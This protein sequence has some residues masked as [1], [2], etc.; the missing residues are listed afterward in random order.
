MNNNSQGTPDTAVS[1]FGQANGTND[2]P[3]LKAFQEYIDAEQAKARKR[4]LGLS[5]FFIVLLTI[6]VVTFTLVVIGVINRNQSLS[7][8]LLEFA[9]RQSTQQAQP[10][11][12]PQQPALQ[13][14][15]A[16]QQPAAAVQH[17]STPPPDLKPVLEKLEM[18]A[19]AI[20]NQ[21]PQPV[22]QPVQPVVQ[23]QPM[24]VTAP[25]PAPQAQAVPAQAPKPVS[26]PALAD[27]EAERIR[28]QLKQERE[29]LA[30]ERKQLEEQRHKE[31]VEKHRRRLYPEYYAKKDAAAKKDVATKDV[32]TKPKESQKPP[33]P[34]ELD[35]IKPKGYFDRNGDAEDEEL[36]EMAR[37]AARRKA[38]ADAAR[39]KAEADAAEAASR[40]AASEAARQ[41]AE[42]AAADA[43]RRK[44][45]ADAARQK[46]EADAAEAKK[47]KAE[48]DADEAKKREAAAEEAPR[49]KESQPPS[50]A[51][52]TSQSKTETIEVGGKDG[53]GVPWIIQR[54]DE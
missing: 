14:N 10:S 48:L 4:M 47:R 12:Q 20:A 23:V 41:K 35:K 50:S 34:A 53:D 2:F 9:L 39:Q 17:I 51:K 26:A 32:G 42:A 29:K 6:V 49:K 13:S 22:V 31:E 30:A 44:A 24:P 54:L 45:Q 8:R 1:I 28:E 11:P 18:L 46:A 15:P 19:R 33:T 40:K 25:A 21:N 37:Q 27:A 16:P 5:V 36:A 43:A 7:D 38:A 3:V 52:P